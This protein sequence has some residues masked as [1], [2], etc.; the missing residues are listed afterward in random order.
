MRRHYHIINGYNVY[1]K[2]MSSIHYIMTGTYQLSSYLFCTIRSVKV[3][4]K[5][6]TCVA[7]QLHFCL[8]AIEKI[9]LLI[10]WNG[11]TNMSLILKSIVVLVN[12]Q[13]AYAVWICMHQC[14]FI[15]M[16]D[17]NHYYF[18]GKKSNNPAIQQRTKNS[19]LTPV[20]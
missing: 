9:R 13:N 12:I 11:W 3:D 19:V 5:S 18:K 20:S 2:I 14:N 7:V 10:S 16:N 4:S 15:K 6:L 17:W 1:W 8:R